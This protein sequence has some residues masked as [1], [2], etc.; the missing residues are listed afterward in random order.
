MNPRNNKDLASIRATLEL[1]LNFLYILLMLSAT[2]LSHFISFC[3]KN[4]NNFPTSVLNAIGEEV[5]SHCSK[6][7]K[8][9]TGNGERFLSE[10]KIDKILYYGS[11]S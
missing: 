2:S 7:D 11:I 4:S 5:F 3:L 8:Y 10:T 6:Y 9:D 1:R